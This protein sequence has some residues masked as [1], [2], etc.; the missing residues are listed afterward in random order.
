VHL[1]QILIGLTIVEIGMSMPVEVLAAKQ[2][3][4]REVGQQQNRQEKER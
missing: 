1:I 2:V 4:A 3:V